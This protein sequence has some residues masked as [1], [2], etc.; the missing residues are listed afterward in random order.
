MKYLIRMVPFIVAAILFHGSAFGAE[1][2]KVGV[3][4]LQEFQNSSRAFQ[5]TRAKIKKQFD[6]MQKKIEDEQ[7][8]LAKLEDDYKKQ[9]IML[10]LDA[11]EDKRREVEKKRRYIKYLS[12]DFTFEIKSA[13]K[14]ETHKLLDE[15]GQILEKIGKDQGY[16]LIL[17]KRTLGLLYYRDAIDMTDQVVAAYDK[18]HP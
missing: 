17:E 14:E 11:K 2:L 6:A 9:S 15:L 18:L 13:E 8:A 10:S 5:R 16:L 7:N 4:D 12:E 1:P 3:V